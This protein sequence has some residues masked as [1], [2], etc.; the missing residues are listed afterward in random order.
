MKKTA[1]VILNWNGQKLLEQFLPSVIANTPQSEA[2]IVVAD[3]NSDDN[4]V[5][6]LKNN[7]PEVKVI[8]LD[9]N[10]GFAEGY[11]RAL[12]EITTEYVVLLNSD[13]EV[14]P[15]WLTPMVSYMD[16]HKSIAA[17]Q[18]KILAQRNKEYFEYAGAAGGYIDKYGYPFCRGR[19]FGTIEKDKGQ[20]NSPVD[21]FWA[22][23]ACLLIRTKDYKDAGG[24]DSRFFAHMEEIDLCWRL[25]ARGKHL[26]CLPQ[27]TVYHVGAAT[28][29]EENPRK[30]FLNFRNNLLMLYKNLPDK[31]LKRTMR[32]RTVLD[33]IAILQMLL[34]FKSKNA[35]AIKEAIKDYKKLKKEYKDIRDENLKKTVVDNIS[36]IY[37]S[38]ILKDF[39]IKNSKV[40]SKLNFLK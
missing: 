24:L 26:I 25:N 14:T 11:N 15:N 31:A 13:V 12:S 9:K 6:F 18:P 19:I 16:N 32:T 33:Y 30:T 23:G 10:Y 36:T 20:Y 27:S 34:T 8:Q 39:Y 38:C 22:S 5:D 7:Y 4:S 28:L 21:I 17:A 35:K 1:V 29:S 3:N 37:P 2:D 40:F